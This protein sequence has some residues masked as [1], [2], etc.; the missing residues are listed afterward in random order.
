MKPDIGDVKEPTESSSTDPGPTQDENNEASTVT[1]SNEKPAVEN[2]ETGPFIDP[3]TGE[4]KVKQEP[5]FE[6][7][8]PS[9]EWISW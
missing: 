3:K 5:R 4:C 7:D 6:D 8:Q 2:N 9:G 1:P